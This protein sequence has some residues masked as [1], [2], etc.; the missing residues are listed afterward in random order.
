VLGT[1]IFRYSLNHRLRLALKWILR[2][3]T[4]E[5]KEERL[6]LDRERI[7]KILLVRAIFRM[8][9]SVLAAPAIHLFRKNFPSARIDF[10]GGP[11]SA[12]LFQNLPLDHRFCITRRFPG[13]SWIYPMLMK[14]LRAT[15]YDLAVDLSCS[16]S[17]MGSFIV[18]FSKARFRVGLQGKWDRWLN[19][20][21]P[22]PREKNKYETLPL[23]LKALGLDPDVIGPSL[24][25]S[26]AEKEAGQRRVEALAGWGRAAPTVG[27]F[28]GGRKAWGKRWPIENFCRLA[29]A[30]Y[31]QGINVVT[32]FGPEEKDLTGFFSDALDPG[33][34]LVSEPS[35]RD[36]AAMVSS[37]DLFI[38]CDSGPMH[39]ACALGTRTIAIFQN[40]N[41]DHWGPPSAL[42]RI[43]HESGGC[44]VD[45]VLKACR[46]E[47][48]DRLAPGCCGE[49]ICG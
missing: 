40:P 10:V 29:A 12:K 47:L 9:D 30:L 2:C 38:T 46:L 8:G 27:V 31:C 5:S 49:I 17:A 7:K 13:S 45:T 15:H 25:L 44:S 36:F 21:I 18:G 22:R 35:L 41:F 43:L 23:F 32:F 39:L 42:A 28:V 6:D 48:S 24:V 37:C 26:S 20:R 11:I 19:V 1:K 14:Q 34:A 4:T 3:V 16:Q 33:I